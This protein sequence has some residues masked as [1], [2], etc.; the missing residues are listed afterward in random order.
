M[1]SS[2]L[3]NVIGQCGE[4][5]GQFLV[6]GLRGEF[7]RP[8]HGEVELAATVVEFTG[9]ARRALVVVQQLAGRGIQR[10]GQDRGLLVAGLD[11]QVFQAGA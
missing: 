5:F 10:L 2:F 6:V 8:V 4:A 7:L 11:A 9:L 1:T 3:V